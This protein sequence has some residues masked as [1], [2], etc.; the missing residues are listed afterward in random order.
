MTV[1][2]ILQDI[3]FTGQFYGVGSKGDQPDIG[4]ITGLQKSFITCI[5]RVAQNVGLV[6]LP[7]YWKY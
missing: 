6:R 4:L 5:A 1:N 3:T 2:A 7:F